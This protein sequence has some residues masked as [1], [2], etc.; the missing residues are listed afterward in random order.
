M[1]CWSELS[2]PGESAHPKRARS[3]PQALSE[4]TLGSALEVAHAAAPL[5][6]ACCWEALAAC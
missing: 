5:D 3:Q 2:L 4:Y 6:G 1:P